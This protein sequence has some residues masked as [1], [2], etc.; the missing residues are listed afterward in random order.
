ARA[1]AVLAYEFGDGTADAR[2]AL[3]RL[4][5]RPSLDLDIASA[6]LALAQ[7]DLKTARD[8][9]EHAQQIAPEDAAALY[10]SGQAALLAG[11]LKGAIADLG[12]AV[13]R[14]PRPL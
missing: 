9:A 3:D 7:S 5:G 13:E 11:D 8:T 6:Y 2:A 10:V 4:S 1:R 12:R 14:E